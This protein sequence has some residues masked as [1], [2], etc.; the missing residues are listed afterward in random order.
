MGCVGGKVPGQAGGA[1][2][3]RGGPRVDEMT[4][5][6]ATRARARQARQAGTH[7]TG[8]TGGREQKDNRSVLVWLA[9]QLGPCTHGV[10]RWRERKRASGRPSA[11]KKSPVGSLGRSPAQHS[12]CSHTEQR[13]NDT[14]SSFRSVQMALLSFSYLD[15]KSGPG[16]LFLAC[17]AGHPRPL[18]SR[19]TT[20]FE[21]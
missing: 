19:P 14:A 17:S 10:R 18:R 2:E 21:C 16:G 7:G 13:R 11:G 5:P 9:E 6:P 4:F 8:R 3:R 12:S 15:F 1:G 20:S